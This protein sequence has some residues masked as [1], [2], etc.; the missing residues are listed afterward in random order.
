[1]SN[2]ES[3]IAVH[4]HLYRRG[5]FLNNGR[6]AKLMPRQPCITSLMQK[7]QSMTTAYRRRAAALSL[8]DRSRSKMRNI[9]SATM[10][11]TADASQLRLTQARWFNV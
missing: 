6:Q 11:A 7:D 9:D 10:S 8:K 5:K 4:L 3:Y 2:I 1:M